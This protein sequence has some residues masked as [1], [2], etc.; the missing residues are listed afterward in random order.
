MTRIIRADSE[1]RDLVSRETTI[2]AVDNLTVVGMAGAIQ[3][4]S[5]GDNS[6]AVE[7]RMASIGGND[8]ME[9]TGGRSVTIGKVL[10]ELIDQIRKSVVAVKQEIIAPVVWIRSQNINVAQLM[11]DTLSMVK[12]L[13]EQTANHTHSNTGNPQNARE[14]KSTGIQADSLSKKYS[15]VIGK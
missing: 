1:N 14:I 5:T 2:K 6:Q 3:H 15:P 8:T 13:A 9:V 11:L 4:I 12:Q 10:I 7:N